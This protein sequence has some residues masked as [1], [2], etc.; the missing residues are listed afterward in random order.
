MAV[1]LKTG[2][3]VF[4]VL[5]KGYYGRP[6]PDDFHPD[7]TQIEYADYQ[8]N[9]MGD[10]RRGLD[11][12]ESRPD[13]DRSRIVFYGPSAGAQLGLILAA[14][15]TRYRGVFLQG[16]GL[17]AYHLTVTPA[18][19]P[20]NFASHIMAPK[21]VLQGRYDEDTPLKTMADPL[22]KFLSEPKQRLVYEGTH[23][24]TDDVRIPAVLPWLNTILG[25]VIK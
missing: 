13:I 16:A 7:A 24:P 1:Y 17:A 15:E 19:N 11:Y 4:S 5:L 22:Y 10:L 9:Q 25:P 8:V 14:V 12:L 3:A 2:R 20:I 18:A 21:F 6:S 23:V